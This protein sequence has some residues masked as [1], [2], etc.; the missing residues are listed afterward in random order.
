LLRVMV[1]SVAPASRTTSSTLCCSGLHV[2][3]WPLRVL[4]LVLS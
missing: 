3:N 2:L 1:S 4:N